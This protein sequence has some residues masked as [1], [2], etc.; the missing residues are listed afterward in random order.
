MEEKKQLKTGL[1]NKISSNGTAYANG[2]IKIENKEYKVILFLNKNKTNE[3]QPDF[4]LI[5]EE[6]KKENKSSEEQAY[7]NSGNNI[8]I[9]DDMLAF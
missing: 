6:I 3:K 8:E 2:K 9:T 7:A 1:W 4:N 5:L